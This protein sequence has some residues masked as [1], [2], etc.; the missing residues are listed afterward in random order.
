VAEPRPV[1]LRWE[2]S[3]ARGHDSVPALVI[4]ASSD[5]R[6][7]DGSLPPLGLGKAEIME[8]VD[9]TLYGLDE[10]R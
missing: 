8:G 4:D 2:L 1:P 10:R 7:L 3:G 6:E 5:L 9:A